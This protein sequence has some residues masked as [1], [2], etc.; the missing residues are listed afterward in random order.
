MVI[1]FLRNCCVDWTV[2]RL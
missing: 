2:C 1:T